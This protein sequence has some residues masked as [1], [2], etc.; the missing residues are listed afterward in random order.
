[1]LHDTQPY[2]YWR[3]H[4]LRFL[5]ASRIQGTPLYYL[6]TTKHPFRGPCLSCLPCDPDPQA[7]LRICSL[8]LPG[9]SPSLSAWL[10]KWLIA[11]LPVV[12]SQVHTARWQEPSVDP[13][14]ARR[15]SMY[16]DAL[17]L[18]WSMAEWWAWQ[19]QVAM[20]W[21]VLHSPDILDNNLQR[22]MLHRWSD[23]ESMYS[24]EKDMA[25]QNSTYA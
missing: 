1:M 6:S 11:S 25:D 5:E 8:S 18:Q 19:S 20:V 4:L 16:L 24:C 14:R 17:W 13:Q 12:P 21:L 15:L 2:H 22:R 23:L 10:A 3:F 7:P 9:P